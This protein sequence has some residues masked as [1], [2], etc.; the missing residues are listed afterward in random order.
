MSLSLTFSP[1]L[2][3]AATWSEISILLLPVAKVTCPLNSKS[4]IELNGCAI[5]ILSTAAVTVMTDSPV[6]LYATTP[7]SASRSIKIVP[8][9]MCP[10]ELIYESRSHGSLAS[11]S[12]CF[13]IS[14]RSDSQIIGDHV[15]YDFVKAIWHRLRRQI[16]FHIIRRYGF[17]ELIFLLLPEGFDEWRSRSHGCQLSIDAVRSTLGGYWETSRWSALYRAQSPEG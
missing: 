2:G 15:T 17:C 6:C 14:F 13:D 11:G 12:I 3:A 4:Q 1:S 10:D 9:R 7:A 16:S 5:V 8:N